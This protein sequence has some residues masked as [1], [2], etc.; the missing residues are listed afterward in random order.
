MCARTLCSAGEQYAVAVSA[1]VATAVLSLD[2]G[3]WTSFCLQMGKSFP[4][5]R[6]VLR[7]SIRK[8]SVT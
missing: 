3:S 7:P 1:E 5:S 8:A 4:F 6:A 2:F